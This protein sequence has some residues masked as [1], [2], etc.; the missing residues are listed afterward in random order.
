MPSIRARVARWI[1]RTFL[2][3]FLFSGP[4][5]KL[6]RRQRP[7]R[8]PSG[9][10]AERIVAG[11]V[12]AVWLVPEGASERVLLYIHGGGFVMCSPGTHGPLAAAIAQ[13]AGARALLP[14]YRLAPEHPFPAALDD[15]LAVYRW[16]LAQGVK[17]EEVVVGGD[18]AGGNLTLATLLSLRDAGVP[19][20]AGAFCLSPATDLTASGES[21]RTRVGDE[22]LLTV[23]FCQTVGPLYV[24]QNDPAAPLLSP[25]FADLRGL[26]PLLI[27]VVTHELLLDDSLRFADVAKRAGVEVSLKIWEGLWHAFQLFDFFPEARQAVAELAAFARARFEGLGPRK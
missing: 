21:F 1:I 6:R 9:V 15:C 13:K 12:P 19:M 5:E 4:I 27:H 25:L 11:G 24:G 3:P 17:P 23:P 7:R 14:D 20:P 8:L 10:R 26:P 2:R 16:L 22:V 18:S